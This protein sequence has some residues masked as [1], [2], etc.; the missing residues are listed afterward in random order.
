MIHRGAIASLA[1]YPAGYKFDPVAKCP[2]KR[3]KKGIELIT[4]TASPAMDDF[5]KQMLLFQNNR[6]PHVNVEV[7]KWNAVQMRAHQR[8]QTADITPHAAG[9]SDPSQ[10]CLNLHTAS[11]PHRAWSYTLATFF[12][13]ILL[14]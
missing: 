14:Q 10:V 12:S 7:F 6:N 11:T 5:V 9:I 13:V 1:P 8:L 3:G 2:Q 4:K